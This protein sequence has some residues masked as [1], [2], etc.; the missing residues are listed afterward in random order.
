MFQGGN[1]GGLKGLYDF[2]WNEGL[3]PSCSGKESSKLGT[4]VKDE[5]LL[6]TAGT[7]LAFTLVSCLLLP[8]LFP[9]RSRETEIL[10]G[11]D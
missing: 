3:A 11:Q 8:E 7:L 9:S 5:R 4:D 1:G 2:F 6:E 10:K